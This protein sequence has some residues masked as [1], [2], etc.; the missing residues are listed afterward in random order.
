M[1]SLHVLIRPEAPADAASIE[2][3]TIAAFREAE[4]TSHNEQDIV[5]ALREAGALTVSLVAERDG[6]VVGHVAISP[7][8][9][10][11]G[12]SGWFGL[13]PISVLPA[14]QGCGIGAC[15]MRAALD[16]L[17]TLGAA[18]CVVL[19][20]PAYYGR[21]GFR[22]EPSLVFP[23]VPAEYFQALIFRGTLPNGA[24]T[25]HPGFYA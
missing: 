8:S 6:A 4:H 9:I 5:R 14:E 17:R 2:A 25:Y 11:D 20:D 24:V 15:L 13:G 18:G 1:T 21:F 22:A 3:V 10:A 19:G 23:R 7:V 16:Q 12:T